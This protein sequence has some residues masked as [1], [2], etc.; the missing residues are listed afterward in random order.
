MGIIVPFMAYANGNGEG[1]DVITPV[2]DMKD[3]NIDCEL[4]I[5]EFYG[6]SGVDY[7]AS[8]VEIQRD[9]YV[10][11]NTWTGSKVLYEKCDGGICYPTYC[12]D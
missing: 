10:L 6:E 9:G 5:Y 8:P 12:Q 11:I 3:Y 2:Y 1:D 7:V 4:Y